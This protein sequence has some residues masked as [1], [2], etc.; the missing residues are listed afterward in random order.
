MLK[1]ISILQH[2]IKILHFKL[3]QQTQPSDE[4]Q[5]ILKNSPSSSKMKKPT[6]SGKDIASP[7]QTVAGKN[8]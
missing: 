4:T 1:H 5:K 7:A 2:R 6:V 3:S 8:L